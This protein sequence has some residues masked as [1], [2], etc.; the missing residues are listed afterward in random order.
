SLEREWMQTLYFE[1]A[2]HPRLHFRFDDTQAAQGSHHQ[3]FAVIDRSVSFVGGIDL[4]ESRWDDRGHRQHNPL[5]VTADGA[6]SKPY[7]DVQ[8]YLAGA[9]TA[10][11]LRDLFADRWAR[12]AGPELTLAPCEA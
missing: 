5:R 7:H 6:P 12:T 10:D 8:A 3:K 4:C 9:E 1:W 11:L 2:T